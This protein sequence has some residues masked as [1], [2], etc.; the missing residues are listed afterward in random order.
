MADRPAG[1]P[2]RQAG[3]RGARRRTDGGADRGDRD[4]HRL[5][6]AQHDGARHC[7]PAGGLAG[8]PAGRGRPR[9]GR[10]RPGPRGKDGGAGDGG[11]RR[12]RG[13]QGD[14]RGDRADH[15]PRPSGRAAAGLRGAVPRPD[16]TAAW[17]RRRRAAGAADGRQPACD[18]RRHRQ[19]RADRACPCA[20]HGGRRG[21]AAQRRFDVP[22]PRPARRDRAAGAAGQRGAA[23]RRTV[24]RA[25]RPAGGGASAIGAAAAARPPG[26]RRVAGRPGGSVPGGHPRRQQPVGAHRGGR[27]RRR[28]PRR[29]SR[30]RAIGCVVCAGAVPV[31]RRARCGARR[32]VHPGRRRLRRRATPPRTGSFA[33]ARRVAGS[34]AADRR[35]RGGLHRPGRRRRGA[36]AGGAGEP[37]LVDARRVGRRRRLD[38][39]RGAGRAGAGRRRHPAAGLAGRGHQH[40]RRDAR[41]RAAEA[42]AMA[43]PVRRPGAADSGRAGV[44]ADRGRRLPGGGGARRSAD[45]LDPL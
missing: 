33:H 42:A 11:L 23:A 26:S 18:R 19:H 24:P 17:I 43:E 34:V 8:G 1:Q 4:V 32:P 13:L 41:R 14:D 10:R 20:G 30:R 39:R 31:P 6:L 3:G 40:R 44:L 16:R 36:G 25:V 7:R 9:A 22:D 28:Q 2:L 27:G 45:D 35:R 15:R 38:D 12:H 29:P 5:G 37:G 21:G